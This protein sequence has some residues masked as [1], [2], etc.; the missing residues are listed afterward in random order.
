M[1]HPSNSCFTGGADGTIRYWTMTPT[2]SPADA[3]VRMIDTRTRS[4][5]KGKS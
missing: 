5:E 1:H 4:S 2:G 3:T